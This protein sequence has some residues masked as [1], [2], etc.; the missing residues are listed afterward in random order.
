MTDKPSQ[1]TN[2]GSNDQLCTALRNAANLGRLNF[3]LEQQLLPIGHRMGFIGPH[4]CDLAAERIEK[5]RA[6]LLEVLEF[7]SAP[8]SPTIHDFGRWRRLA[9]GSGHNAGDKRL[10]EG[11]SA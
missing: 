8:T 9:N 1:P 4:L 2:V 11:K 6:A 7:Q 10:A 5:L 3:E